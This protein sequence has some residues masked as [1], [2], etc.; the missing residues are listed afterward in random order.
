[1]KATVIV[2]ARSNSIRL[3][4]KMSQDLTNLKVIEW[5][6]RRLKRSKKVK[7]FVLATTSNKLD[8]PLIKIAKKYNFKI[9]KGDE[10]DVLNRF[11]KCAKKMKLKTIVRVC[12]DNPFIDS[13]QVDRL[14]NE[15]K[16]KKL[17]YMYNNM[18]TVN[19]L[20]A[21]GFGAEIFNFSSLN[22]AH[23]LAK[24]KSDREHVTKFIREN[25]K[26]F[27]VKCLEPISG[28]D[29]PYLKFDIDTK[30]DLDKLRKIILKHNIKI[31]SSG[32]KIVSSIIISQINKFLKRL[33]P[34]NRSLTG[35]DNY[36]TLS[37]INKLTK[38]NIKKIPSD[39]KVYDWITPREWIV[40]E[41]W[42]KD[43][44]TN[45]KIVDFGFN[46]LSLVNYSSPFKG[47]MTGIKLKKKLHFHPH[48]KN[49]IPYKT[50]Y[51]KKDWGFCVNKKT[52]EKITRSKNKFEI[53]INSRFKKSNL[54]YGEKLIRGK[55]KKEILISTYICHPSMANDN[56]SGV[57]LTAFLTKFINSL[58]QRHW[59]YR[60]VFL[61]ETIGAISYLNKNEK[62][63]RKIDFGLVVCNVG[64]KGKFSLKQ[65][66]EKNHFL[67]DLAKNAIKE[68]GHK[69]KI[70]PFDIN[71]SD[72]RQYSSQFF[73]IN[74]CSIFKDKYYDFKQYHS[75]ADNLKFVKA[76]NIYKTLKIYQ[77]LIQKLEKQ[78]IFKTKK[79][80][81]EVMLSKYNLYPKLGGSIIPKKN[82]LS[83]LDILL[84]ILFLSNGNRTVEQI[85]NFL[86]I[87][88]NKLINDY[89]IFI[90]K[91]L[92]ERV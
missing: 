76:E 42:I 3:K 78:I 16:K 30:K 27:K 68:L 19:N 26:I 53:N 35:K 40:K 74:I 39:K 17:D 13:N 22:K 25:N 7:N 86:K 44:K 10:K 50:T 49:E 70:H 5:V 36:K 14:V 20:N 79:T 82:K 92:V 63:M 8:R 61:P 46:N 85:S 77:N 37:E 38:I 54:V 64:G 32:K 65:S 31:S 56:L 73:K 83:S 55:S 1:M 48:L 23:K 58:K 21:D 91:K 84:W 69:P 12:A 28:L 62:M 43:T 18:Q 87:D 72:E 2:Q 89:K 75:S 66:F 67:N 52:Y 57:I 15:F 33:F 6:L 9:F 88:K 80:K 71:G 41:A 11:F 59:S 34:L 90:K 60:I 81:G 29:F 47:K 4:Y 45:K 24:K 51:F